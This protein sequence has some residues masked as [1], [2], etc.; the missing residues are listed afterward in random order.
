M[1][2]Q[3][4]NAATEQVTLDRERYERWAKGVQD[5]MN[6]LARYA[7]ARR[8]IRREMTLV[9]NVAK[10]LEALEWCLTHSTGVG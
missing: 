4:A 10:A 2:T 6:G 1:D 8:L 5:T 3:F 7:G 9:A